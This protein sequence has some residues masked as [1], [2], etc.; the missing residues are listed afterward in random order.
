MDKL[1]YPTTLEDWKLLL[2][3]AQEERCDLDILLKDEW[4]HKVVVRDDYCPIYPIK[5]QFLS[6]D[7]LNYA[8]LKNFLQSNEGI[9]LRA[10]ALT[11]L[12]I[13]ID[14]Y[15][16][17]SR[18]V[19]AYVDANGKN[20]VQDS[21][22]LP[23]IVNHIQQ[24][25][26][27]CIS[28]VKV[29]EDALRLK[30]SYLSP[31]EVLQLGLFDAVLILND[32]HPLEGLPPLPLV[33]FVHDL[34]DRQCLQWTVTYAGE[35]FEDKII[36]GLIDILREIVTQLFSQPTKFIADLEL[37]SN[38]QKLKIDA[39]NATDGEF[40]A[41][42]RLEELFE[43]AVQL[44]PE[45]EAIEF[46][47]SRLTYCELN[48]ACNWV[49]HWLLGSS[50]DLKSG[51]LIA[52]YLDKSDLVVVTMLG[53]WKAGAAFVP[54]EPS[55]PLERV[56]FML[57]D[58]QAKRVVT[59]RH[60]TGRLREILE[61]HQSDIQL[62]EVEEVF[63][64]YL[65]DE[66]VES[67][68]CHNPRL[69]L[70]SEQIAYVTYTS[71]T[72]GIPKGV[73][74][75]HCSVVNSITD[76]SERYDMLRAGEERVVL[77]AAYV[78]EPFMRQMLIALINSQTLVVVSDNVRLHPI[79]F[80]EF[81]AQHK[82]TYLNGTR[83]VLQHFD[84]RGCESLKKILLVGEELTASAL[85]LLREK[86]E[87]RIVN[88]YA[89]TEA[90]FVTAI[91]EFEAAV[92]FR[93][94]RSIG[95]PLRNVK[96][97][98][99][100]Q[101]MKE[102]PIG[103]IGDLYIGGSGVASGYLN[104]PQL[105]AER[106]LSNPF[107]TEQEKRSELNARIYK[108]GDLVRRL[109]N[110]ELEFM[111][112]SDFQL[113]LN[114][115]RVEPGE[116]EA[117]VTEYPGIRQCVVIA[118][119]GVA[120]SG[121]SGDWF[122]IGYF[123]ADSSSQVT[124][125]ELL[126]YL[127]ERLI[128]VMIPARMIR[129]SSFP[130]NVNGKIDRR[131]LSDLAINHKAEVLPHDEGHEAETISNSILEILR[132]IWSEVLRVPV[133]SIQDNDDFF[134]L[135][136]Q[137]ITCIQLLIRI[138]HQLRFDVT[139]EDIFRLKTL[140]NLAIHL[141]QHQEMPRSF[142]QLDT[143][144]FVIA[145]RP[146]SFLAN[147]LQQGLMYHSMKSSK[148][149]DAYIMQTVYRYRC[150]V[151]PVLMKEAWH[152]AQVKYP[153]LRLRFRWEGE[154]LQIIE[155]DGH[156]PLD[157]Q[158]ID[159]S[160]KPNED[161]QTRLIE[162]L[163][164]GDRSKPYLL[165]IGPLFRV[166]LIKLRDDFFALLF[167]C[168]HIILD[169]WSL[170]LMHD[171]VHRM[172]LDLLRGDT[173]EPDIDTAYIAAQ[174]YWETHRE[175]HIEYWML[176]LARI[177]ER[178]D[179]S[180][181][182]NEGSR[183]KVT[184]TSYDLIR[185]HKTK[186]MGIGVRPT[187]MIK[188]ACA[189][190]GLTLHSV[191]QFVWHKVLYAIGGGETT[192]V[193]TIV[194]GRNLPID[195]I[196]RSVGLFINTLP[197]VVDHEEQETKSVD[198]AISDIQ[199]SVNVMNSR[200][201]VELGRLQSGEMKR[202][203]FD[204]LLVLENYPRLLNKAD[205][206]RFA[207]QLCFERTFDV[208]KVDYP[209]AVVAFEENQ[210][211]I[212]NLWYAGEL[213]EDI[214]IDTL[215]DTAR[216]L[217]AQISENISQPVGNL[218]FIS[219]GTLARL[220]AWNN[221]RTTFPEEKTLHAVFEDMVLQW[222][223]KIAVVFGT[224][225][226]TY[227]QL[228]DRANQLAYL[229]LATAELYANDL[230]A[231]LL[232]KSEMTIVAI[233]AVWK[234]GS[235]YV[236]IDP[237]SPDERIAFILEDTKA[238]LV[239][240]NEVYGSRLRQFSDSEQTQ[241]LEFEKMALEHQPSHNPATQTSS[242]DLAY[243]IYTSGTTGKPKGVQVEHRGVVN[244]K[245]AL[246]DLFS[247]NRDSGKEV[248]LS[249][250][251]YVFD[252][253]VEQMTDA[254]LN[255]QKLVVLDDEMRTDQQ[256]L[257]HYMNEHQVTY[258][259]G[260]PSVLSLYDFSSVK[261]L[262][263]I[264]AIGEDFTEPVFNK[265][266]RTFRGTIING[267]GPTEIS[268]TSHKRLYEV[269]EQRTNKSIGYPVANTTC[270]VLNS[271][272]KRVPIGGV[273]ELFIGGIGVTR[274]YLNRDYETARRFIKNPFQ[275]AEEEQL[276]L[277]ARLYRTGDLVRWLPNGELEYLGRNDFQIKI[278]GQ[279]VE[280]GEIEAVLSSYPG[281]SRAF[282]IVR[283]HS[284]V[285]VSDTEIPQKYLVGFY[286]S[287]SELVEQELKQW[288]R[289]KLAASLVPARLIR[290]NEIPV[291]TSGKLDTRKLPDTDFSFDTEGDYVAPSN[292]IES[293]LCKIWAK[294]LD[295]PQKYIGIY[296]D[297]FALGG[298]SLRAIALSQAIVNKFGSVFGVAAAFENTTIKAQ[299]DHIHCCTTERTASGDT[300]SGLAALHVG[301]PPVSLSQERLLFID[302]FVGGTAAYNIPFFVEMVVSEAGEREALATSLQ[303][304]LKRHP[305]LHTL[306][307]GERNGVRLQYLLDEREAVARFTFTQAIA[308][309][310]E[311][312]DALLLGEA[313][314]IFLLGAELPIRV[315]FFKLLD[316]DDKLYIS[317]ILHHS[318]F[319]G[320][321]WNVFRRELSALVSG[322]SESDLTDL[323]VTYADFSLWQRQRLNGKRLSTLEDFW[324][325]TL[326]GFE[327]LNLP[328]DRSRPP[329]F[330][331]QGHEI[332]FNID[333]S[334]SN[335][336]KVLAKHAKVSLYSVL[337]GAY[338]LMLATYTGQ[339]D[340][341]VGTPSANRELPEFE[342]VIGFFANLLVLRVEVDG[343]ATL[344]KYLQS[345]GEMVAQAQVHQDFPFEQ[346]VKSLQVEKDPSR[347]PI[348]QVVFSLVND[349]A[350]GWGEGG[351]IKTYRPD[352]G[353]RTMAKFDLSATITEVPTG[354]IGNFTYAESL[355]NSASVSYWVLSFQYVLEEFAR[356]YPVAETAR[357][358][359]VWCIDQTIR[360]KIL[361]TAS[362]TSPSPIAH[363]EF[364]KTLHTV[365]EEIVVRWPHEVAV[366]FGNQQLTYC[367]LNE[368]ANQLAHLLLATAELQANDL[369]ALLLDKTEKM[370][371]VIL[372]VWKAGAGYV[373]IDPSYPDDRIAFILEDTQAK[374]AIA[375]EAYGERLLQ[376]PGSGRL[377][378]VLEFE[379][380]VLDHQ[381]SHNPVTQ[382]LSQDIAYTIY[383]SGTTGKPKGVLISHQNV[384]SFRRDI[385]SRYFGKAF[386]IRQ[387]VLFLSNY[388]FDFSVE[389]LS[390]SILSGHKLI[391]PLPLSIFDNEFYDYVNKQGLTYI[392]GTP[393]Q[394]QQ[395]DL[396]QFDHL[397]LVL[398]AGEAFQLHHFNKIR[399]EYSGPLLN[400]YGTTET[401]VYN[402]VIRFES[403]DTYQNA[404]GEPLSNTR[405]Y[406][407]GSEL[408]LLPFGAV[409]E[410]FISGDC[411]SKG[412]LNRN[413]LTHER[414]LPDAFQT[415][416]QQQE[417][418][419]AVM[420]KTGDVVRRRVDGEI[421][422]LG[423]ND[424][425]VKINGLRIELG[426]VEAMLSAYP[427]INQ[428][429]V[430]LRQD[431]RI[432]SFKRL[433]GYYIEVK[434]STIE[435]GEVLAF[436]R[437][438][439][440]PSSV[441]ALLVKVDGTL[442]TTINGK[443]DVSA[444]PEVEFGCKPATY[445]TPRN[446][447][448]S[449][450]C[451]IWSQL[452]PDSNIGIDDDFFL[453]G[454]DSITAL[455][456]ASQIQEE[457]K[458]KI[459]VKHIF[460]FPTVRSFVENALNDIANKPGYEKQMP[461]TGICPMIPIQKWF[462]AKSLVNRAY[463]NQ[464]FAIRTPPLEIEK[465]ELALNKIVDYHDV[466]RLRFRF[467][468]ANCEEEIEQIYSDSNLRVPLHSLD[469]QNLSY[470]EVQSKLAKWQ[471]RFDLENGPLYSA[472]YLYG[473]EDG[474]A[475]V[476]IAMHH[477]IVDAV[478]WRIL[479]R[480]LE[481]LY[482]GGELGS[483]GS[484]Y[485]QW[486]QALQKYVST[487][488]ERQ[489]WAN[490]ADGV[491]AWTR[492]TFAA[493]V[494]GLQGN[495]QL[496]RVCFTLGKQETQKL[497]TESH[498]AYDTRIDDL[499]LT[500]VGYALRALTQQSLNYVTLE[501]HGR[502]A[503]DNAPD[504]RDT[505]GWF[506]TMH[507]ILIEV[508]DDLYRSITAVKASHRQMPHN[509]IGYGILCSTYGSEQ[510][511]LPPVSFNYLG[512]FTD[513]SILS[514]QKPVSDGH[515]VW[516][517][518]TT[519]CGIGKSPADKTTSDCTIDVTM[520]C[521]GGHLI[522]EVDSHLGQAATKQFATELKARLEDIINHTSTIE[523]ERDDN[524]QGRISLSSSAIRNF[525]P[526]ILVNE[527]ETE[528]TLF[529]LPPGEGGAESYL[530]NIA[531]QLPGIRLVLF[532][533]VHL[534]SPMSS[535]EALAQYYIEE[536]RKLQPYGP[537]SFLGWSFGGVLSLEIAIQLAQMEEVITNLIF[538]DSFFNVKKATND[539][540][541]CGVN[542]IIDP[543]NYRYMPKE[544]ELKHLHVRTKNVLLFKATQP[545]KQFQGEHQY[546]LFEYYARSSDNNLETWLPIS[547]ISVEQLLEDTHFSWVNNTT[548]IA[549][550]ASKV[551]ELIQ[552][553]I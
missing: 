339:Q 325:K 528:P 236:P 462:F 471:S 266:R 244:L 511:P 52:L 82:I 256:R 479:A 287:N 362:S 128:R 20:K 28:A 351:S 383:T 544:S 241:V 154:A 117:R 51:E 438:Q 75:T 279:R 437:T 501:R 21:V 97:Y 338:C 216:T 130:V 313:E 286:L 65:A 196:E 159:L 152:Y 317:I 249:F 34:D 521:V 105:T 257:Y 466:F 115:V 364:S 175:K 107:Q 411:V 263:R 185:E 352:N 414:F 429:A 14:A 371:V 354:L 246:A 447:L 329:Q 529:I 122:L 523:A 450:L 192:V 298:D 552:S 104:R 431:R 483:K 94:D 415:E 186:R 355:F 397:E 435:P 225:Q 393:T 87:G 127:E 145:S 125:A 493:M 68:L 448:E 277:N 517:L 92:G 174:R 260:T 327:S 156:M 269:G 389:Q 460:D 542:N 432:P 514:E 214:A 538:I 359:D 464:Y 394:I 495:E 536:I 171:E 267:Y 532:N 53:I 26:L 481:I 539:I 114:G 305:A 490:I 7:G 63:E 283:T 443:L 405:L 540:G 162:D 49:A 387:A 505:V 332:L 489:L 406:V 525:E 9:S 233:L 190:R 148:S 326:A 368:R 193:G 160:K 398:V 312:L 41:T 492:E 252:H 475:R 228:N 194:S 509:G 155:P 274:G 40:P 520:R 369:V 548:S 226:L 527:D 164:Q 201:T 77:F 480:D 56:L 416:M 549:R 526:Y 120:D 55:Y 428:C 144:D 133:K 513:P 187:S 518:D 45:H 119:K 37:V 134:R 300:A 384:I 61:A 224:H 330:E 356:L 444:L 531:K 367:Q 322:I 212:I 515:V 336:L 350:L 553:N 458:Q 136:G 126:E 211:L 264:D 474:T 220:D 231:L 80:S 213:F 302:E 203:L 500:A 85:R 499:L 88:E 452:L 315:G 507:P 301:D 512:Q 417:G 209:L 223:H 259:S 391:L 59:N 242:R 388:V 292:E 376:L 79:R 506:T 247:L 124:E 184:L 422:F 504:V 395:F 177:R 253:F 446:R 295:S 494:K 89:F 418:R 48:K 39:W 179:L 276:G 551:R 334:I 456:L 221:T 110:G 271:S 86:F 407:L 215:F 62:I 32:D 303:K 17:G 497:L 147:G 278:Y 470:D 488:E 217:F 140:R 248:L 135:G 413:D 535:F 238:K 103:A 469:I 141:T 180:G 197:V 54:I 24:Y 210:E 284:S 67:A 230:V 404:L 449:R 309:N 149:D 151:N 353:G 546:R 22:L 310:K 255:G 258:L 200:S 142:Q 84:L 250:S 486:A 265:I 412:Y 311:E 396:S 341:V 485:R 208:D 408:Q 29:I 108:T 42:R 118:R 320:W 363:D 218:Q 323:S 375:N 319:D 18:S 463:W 400:A 461:L 430:L 113:K 153:S 111:G 533:N 146:I 234:T 165:D 182:L 365:F 403:N 392:S 543:I 76:L 245:I 176:Q 58:T 90:A 534:Q 516:H 139:V 237:S 454:G 235:G 522:A 381:P 441:P 137:S 50:G 227:R 425:Q 306:L 385:T 35:L 195:G 12:H 95:R 206:E 167:S 291:T 378:Q 439:L 275:T 280:L 468:V 307:R 205:A 47:N 163:R 106:F 96:C 189:D 81:I 188:A 420:Y 361:A 436:L 69:D 60:H 64:T 472:A 251:N 93:T 168:H 13:I 377:L 347:H 181:L 459:S 72:T 99:L 57:H 477:L 467:P 342:G 254:L 31:S 207:E 293:E 524:L 66:S 372:A 333:I 30:D 109:P 360:A 123:V 421:E 402:T 281:I 43:D 16:H 183:Y 482:K 373:P 426:E 491:L 390:L 294:I 345:I 424:S 229:L 455:Q 8:M 337:L 33:F 496:C 198:A 370:I 98:V 166:Y 5:R 519:L 328:L 36:T 116:I 348:V 445:T 502:E 240:A 296:S 131:A 282:V 340:I 331:Y 419:C 70:G 547:L 498:H 321:S 344:L 508:S 4:R 374:L 172:Y 178:S 202:R 3:Q 537:Y 299:A 318:C 409:G 101:N 346:L 272:M 262:T 222:P 410:L 1:S 427:G 451:H 273:G 204:T 433:V 503:F 143:T 157:W 304:L 297:F 6:I 290:I 78:F 399:R 545:S 473:F 232:D 91:K 314:H 288:M 158:F 38:S 442:P 239:V 73:P 324:Q 11:A 357:I 380:M 169:G 74:K 401:T 465:L 358:S 510:A 343:E 243:T 440:I 191:L 530:N 379:Q 129:L 102:V 161:I 27:T 268:I 285:S 138:W 112:R 121:D 434:A 270:Y 487:S 170:S 25:Q 173:V 150:S 83:S 15:G 478:S 100:C 46:E 366:V 484:S 382:T 132:N 476:W 316:N 219:S 550:I 308:A 71:G 289:K 199:A 386:G 453:C 2:G 19:I 10:F 541:L 457:L 23:T 335:K 261:S 423:R 349:D 44:F